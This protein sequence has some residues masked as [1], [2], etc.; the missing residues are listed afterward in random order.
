MATSFQ[1]GRA[2][3]EDFEPFRPLI[4]SGWKLAPSIGSL[5]AITVLAAILS[6]AGLGSLGFNGSLLAPKASR[7]DPAAGLKRIFGPQGWIE[8]GKSLLK[9]TLLGSIGAYMLWSASKMSIGL[10]ASDVNS[11]I[12]AMGG[13][14][15]GILF[16]MAGGLLL[17]AGIDVPIQLIRLLQKLRMSKQEVKDESKETEGS[18][19]AKGAIRAAP[20]R[21]LQARHAQGGGRGACRAHQPDPFRG[22]AAL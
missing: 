16:A 4:E 8:L 13:T 19:E 12:G 18:P 2:D 7:I 1:F 9:V 21:G 3:I 20:A 6:Q 15:I 14:L 11:A 5:F 22:R 17:I 10:V